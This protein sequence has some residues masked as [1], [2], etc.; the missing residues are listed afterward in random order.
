MLMFL[1]H[2]LFFNKEALES[3]AGDSA[4]EYLGLVKRRPSWFVE[5]GHN[6]QM[7]PEYRE[8]CHRFRELV[9]ESAA[10]VKAREKIA[11]CW[12]RKKLDALK[13]KKQLL[14]NESQLGDELSSLDSQV[15]ALASANEKLSAFEAKSAAKGKSSRQVKIG[16]SMGFLILGIVV[17]A[18]SLGMRD[19]FSVYHTA[20]GI[21]LNLAGFFWPMVTREDH[22]RILTQTQFIHF[23][24]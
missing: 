1:S 12:E 15:K 24:E 7:L 22:N 9:G 13:K 18:L 19:L 21:F 23:F 20:A 6:F 8:I 16:T 11:A 5:T 3:I 17:L 10:D 4:D 2:F 14:S